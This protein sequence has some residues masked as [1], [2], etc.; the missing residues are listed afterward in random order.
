[1]IT[2]PMLL[3][4]IFSIALI[5]IAIYCL[6]TLLEHLKVHTVQKTSFYKFGI[7]IQL[8]SPVLLLSLLFFSWKP[9]EITI[10]NDTP[11]IGTP[12]KSN[13]LTPNEFDWMQFFLFL[14][15]A[16]VSVQIIILFLSYIRTKL[17]LRNAKPL[18][19]GL[20]LIWADNNF[21]GPF[22][23]GLIRPKI[24]FPNLILDNWSDEYFEIA[25]THE[26]HH[27]KNHDPLWKLLSLIVRS[28]LFFLP[29]AHLIHRKFQFEIEN[30]CDFKTLEETK[31]GVKKYG[32]LLLDLAQIPHNNSL[33]T[34]SIND[35]TLKRR[36]IEMKSRKIHRPILRTIMCT[37]CFSIASI[38]IASA[39][40]ITKKKEQYDIS[41]EIFINNEKV[42]KT[43]VGAIQHRASS[44]VI[45]TEN[46]EKIETEFIAYDQTIPDSNKDGIRIDVDL[47][48]IKSNKIY[49]YNPSIV[50]HPNKEATIEVGDTPNNFLYKMKVVVSRI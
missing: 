28:L 22:C 31:C 12:N 46:G 13:Y 42:A 43:R 14:Y 15:S 3:T 20:H 50:T 44:V 41:A 10:N 8:L 2:N 32:N 29:T 4:F 5:N 16:A 38:A 1:M 36:I 39:S 19:R 48:Y 17:S 18:K 45:T 7:L 26:S 34:T 35:T 9:I 24:Y 23:F 6:G 37:L 11:L 25:H 30:F 21:H 47:R 27:A 49:R 40:G 33:L